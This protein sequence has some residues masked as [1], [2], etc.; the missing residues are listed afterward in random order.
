MAKDT[1][2]IGRSSGYVFGG[3]YQPKAYKPDHMKWYKYV[4]ATLAFSLGIWMLLY[5]LGVSA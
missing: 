1:W 4:V 3:N 5:S 2:M